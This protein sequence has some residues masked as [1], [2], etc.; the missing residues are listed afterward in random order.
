MAHAVSVSQN[1]S[2]VKSRKSIPSATFPG[3][4][5]LFS[6]SLIRKIASL[7]FYLSVT[8]FSQ[9]ENDIKRAATKLESQ[10]RGHQLTG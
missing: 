3:L 2:T 8:S 1:V 10:A 9:L 7:I 6:L 4:S 5:C